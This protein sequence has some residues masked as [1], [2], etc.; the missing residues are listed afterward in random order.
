[1][2]MIKPKFWDKENSFIS[3]L[4]YP[5]SLI[6]I[7]F[8]FIKRKFSKIY[9]FKIPII[10][11]GN[12]YVGGTGKTPTSI[13]L[14][15]DIKKLGKKTVILRKYYKVHL[16]EHDLIR[17]NFKN[18]ILNRSRIDGLLEAERSKYDVVILDDGLQD[19]NIKKDLS[20]VCFNEKQ[21]IGNGYVLPA[22]PLREKLSALK[23]IDI[24]IINGDK[25]EGFE[26]KILA[27]NE[28][29]DIFYS[30]FEP[31][32]IDQFRNKKLFALAG[33]GNPENFFKLIEKNN[34]NIKKKLIFP[35]HYNFKKNEIDEILNSA[36]REDCQ[37]IMTEKDYFKFKGYKTE[38]IN[39]LSVKLQI[40]N[41]EK[42]LNRIINLYDKKI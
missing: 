42:L 20:I 16:D 34:L 39:F 29:I 9:S 24:V 21:L 10:C 1:M 38:R 18:L 26:K 4:L 30:S 37:I 25:N 12:I 22:G 19:Y 2:I 32:N 6:I 3:I 13:L 41:K 35:D 8:I 7:F 5:I 36:E 40:Q 15:N 28:K 17:K 23:N 11:I 14:A 33:I 31:I 27:I